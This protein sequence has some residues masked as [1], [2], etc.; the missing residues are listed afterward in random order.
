M[1]RR[2]YGL[3][4]LIFL[5]LMMGSLFGSAGR[6]DLPMFWAYAGI[7]LV[8]LGVVVSTIDPD[9]MRERLRPSGAGQDSLKLLRGLG[10][11]LFIGLHAFAGLDVGRYHWSDTVPLS[12]QVGGLIG[13]AAAMAIVVWA[14][15]VNRFFSSAVRIQHDRD[16]HVITTGPYQFVRHPGYASF[17]TGSLCSALA[18]GSWWSLLPP[19][20]FALLF[21]RRTAL[22]D[23][24][25]LK[26]LEGY[27]EYAKRVRYRLVPGLW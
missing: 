12:L 19:T 20:I 24:F 16:H 8:I 14:Q 1:E 9:L 17:I 22:E 23:C 2:Q 18:L 27:P 10:L 4:F 15:R 25:L 7:W 21:I 13:F 5:V 26:Q 6:W 11:V 3:S